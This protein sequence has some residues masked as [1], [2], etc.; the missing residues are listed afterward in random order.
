MNA[1]VIAAVVSGVCALIAAVVTAVA[2]QSAR[3][4]ARALRVEITQQ[5]LDAYKELWGLTQAGSVGTELDGE[6]RQKIESAMF[7]W[8][9]TSGNGIFLSARSR[10]VLTA[11]Q[12]NL[13][14][15]SVPWTAI[16]EQMSVLRASLREDVGSIGPS[17]HRR[18]TRRRS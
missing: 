14:D 7:A 13:R 4:A 1:T 3:Y 9:F 18:R 15:E 17:D 6:S 16:V 5:R 11:L 12:A 2:A 10:D 8:Y